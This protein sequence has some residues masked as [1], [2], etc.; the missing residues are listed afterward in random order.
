M[1]ITDLRTVAVRVPVERPTAI[2]TRQLS[3]RGIYPVANCLTVEYFVLEQDVYNFER[4]V[5]PE[6][7]LRPQDGWLPLPTAPGIGLTFDAQMITR[8]RKG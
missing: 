3:A 7:R 5:T 2:A 8:W 6:T 1:K 4:L